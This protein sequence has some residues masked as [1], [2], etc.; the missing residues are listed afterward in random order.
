VTVKI[1]FVEDSPTAVG[2]V[3]EAVS[4]LDAE[5]TLV[6]TVGEAIEKIRH[7]TFDVVL[8]DLNLPDSSGL[9]TV[10]RMSRFHDAIVVFTASSVEDALQT[11]RAGADSYCAKDA[12]GET[13][14][15][16]ILCTLARKRRRTEPPQT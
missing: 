11:V 15:K 8:L 9:Y 3:K 14:R 4:A 6:S 5:L 16:E 13:I 10:E 2:S 1:L 7:G 12:D